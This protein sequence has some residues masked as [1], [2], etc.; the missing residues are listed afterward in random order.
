GGEPDCGSRRFCCRPHSLLQSVMLE[1]MSRV[2]EPSMN[3]TPSTFPGSD[4]AARRPADAAPDSAADTPGDRDRGTRR[5]ILVTISANVAIAIA[6]GIGAFFSGSGALLAE[7]LHSLSDTG[8]GILLLL[9]Q[10]E[11]KEPPTPDHPLGKGRA[12]YFW[13]FVV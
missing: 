12:T 5:S 8:N 9:G 4:S 11:A 13:S 3:H 10:R 1:S 2:R 6:K 7:A